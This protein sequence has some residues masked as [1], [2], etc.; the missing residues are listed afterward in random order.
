MDC[1]R[2]ARGGTE[3]RDGDG[4]NKDVREEEDRRTERKK[5]VLRQGREGRERK[6]KKEREQRREWQRNVK[7]KESESHRS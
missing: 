2:A 3:G 4:R 7:I 6:E 5:V 1:H